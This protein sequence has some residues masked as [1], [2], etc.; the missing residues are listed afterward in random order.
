[1]NKIDEL[2]FIEDFLQRTGQ[3]T[4]PITEQK[5]SLENQFLEIVKKLKKMVNEGNGITEFIKNFI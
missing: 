3:K 5:K 2:L 1:M 4:A